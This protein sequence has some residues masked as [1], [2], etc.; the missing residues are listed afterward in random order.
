MT[1]S[2]TAPLE[3]DASELTYEEWFFLWTAFGQMPG[4]GLERINEFRKRTLGMSRKEQLVKV[5]LG[6]E[7]L[8]ARG[9]I[10]QARGKNGALLF[11]DK[12]Q[13]VYEGVPGA[14]VVTRTTH[15]T[16]VKQ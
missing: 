4:A 11:D 16:P 14:R 3:L 5:R 6:L 13:P 10:R 8:M 15:V 12:Q 2:K 7:A 9:F 1:E